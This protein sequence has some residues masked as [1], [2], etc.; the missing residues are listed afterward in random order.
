MCIFSECLVHLYQSLSL[1]E[2]SLFDIILC[3]FCC[4]KSNISS[5]R[6]FGIVEN[7][8]GEDFEEQDEELRRK[9]E[10]EAEERMLEE[11]LEY[12]RQIENEAK[13]KHLEEQQ[14]RA[15][16]MILETGS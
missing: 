6:D 11:T 9:I 8:S 16:G 13:K 3:V 2:F 5:A 12:Q 10:L 1:A 14:K 15:S 7:G 4:S